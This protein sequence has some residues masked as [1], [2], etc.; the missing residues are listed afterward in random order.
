M[1]AL[2][3]IIDA[4]VMSHNKPVFTQLVLME[5]NFDKILVK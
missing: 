2:I 3:N 5:A 4:I 1:V